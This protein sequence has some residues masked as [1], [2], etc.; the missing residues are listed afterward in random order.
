[1]DGLSKKEDDRLGHN[2]EQDSGVL[3]LGDTSP[4]LQHFLRERK[5]IYFRPGLKHT[6]FPWL[7]CP[8]LA[9]WLL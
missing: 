8:K 2:E 9:K 6:L 3:K 5:N 1:M 4:E 7:L